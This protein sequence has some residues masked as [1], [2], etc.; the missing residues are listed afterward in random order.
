MKGLLGPRKKGRK[1]CSLYNS[2]STNSKGTIGIIK[3]L[4]GEGY[5]QI[6]TKTGEILTHVSGDIIDLM[7]E[8]MILAVDIGNSM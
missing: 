1:V 2:Q 3:G 4:T 5:F 8:L 7:I 6:R